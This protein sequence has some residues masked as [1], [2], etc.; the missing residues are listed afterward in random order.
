VAKTS[1]AGT[2]ELEAIS[3]QFRDAAER[4][5]LSQNQVAKLSGVSR[6]HVGVALSGGNISVAVLV[7]LIRVLKINDLELGDVTLRAER[8]AVNPHLVEHARTLLDRAAA[9]V[10]DAAELLREGNL[11]D[12]ASRLVRQVASEARRGKARARRRA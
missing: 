9:D 8:K 10:R 11:G 7:K 2:P 1:E 5:G 4:L 12:H 3:E 6:K